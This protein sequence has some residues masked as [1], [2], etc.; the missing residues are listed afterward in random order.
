MCAQC[1]LSN[2]HVCELLWASFSLIGRLFI[3]RYDKSKLIAMTRIQWRLN[4]QR[5][6]YTQ[7]I[8]QTDSCHP[9]ALSNVYNRKIILSVTKWFPNIILRQLCMIYWLALSDWKANE[10]APMWF[11]FRLWIFSWSH[12][13]IWTCIGLR[14][15]CLKRARERERDQAWKKSVF[16]I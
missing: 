12:L 15:Q 10:A 11:I 8:N 2:A 9:T 14:L 6:L 13:T 5:I 3:W 16:C 4:F 1:A 7:R